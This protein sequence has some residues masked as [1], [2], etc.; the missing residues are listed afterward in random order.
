[1]NE[2]EIVAQITSLDRGTLHRWIAHGWIK[3]RSA[4][5]GYR[6]DDG[7]VAR[8]H[9]ICDLCFDMGFADEE[10]AL[11]LSL[12][13]QLHDT[14]RMLKA[15]AAAVGEQSDDVKAAILSRA[16]LLSRGE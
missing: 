13:D 11:I 7:D 1:M 4:P 9:F 2:V 5:E 10:L 3:P 14:R 12:V 8:T 6:F 16:A 15:M